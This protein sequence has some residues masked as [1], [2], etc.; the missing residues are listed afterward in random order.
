MIVRGGIKLGPGS[1]PASKAG[2]IWGR[3]DRGQIGW[4]PN[5]PHPYGGSWYIRQV[6]SPGTVKYYATT[7]SGTGAAKTALAVDGHRQ[8]VARLGTGTT[9]TG[10]AGS[11]YN[12]GTVVEFSSTSGLTTYETVFRIPTLPDG[13][14]T[15][16]MWCGFHDSGSATDAVDGIYI[17]LTTAD[18]EFQFVTSNNSTRTTTDTGVTA[19]GGT[20][21]R[22]RIEITNNSEARCYL[23]AFATGPLTTLVATNSTNIPSGSTR[24]TFGG[25]LN[26]IK[27]AG[28]TERTLDFSYQ[29][30]LR[31][32]IQ[33]GAPAV[34]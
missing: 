13:T 12:T 18:T 34:W 6:G 23:A 9:T 24:T 33:S 10:R 3:D 29:R 15:F 25:G 1:D 7:V 4:T 27:S 19:A 21:Y 32:T 8:C 14:E 26:I 5:R 22:L 2:A 16:S 11:I 28:T 30:S 31:Q 17:K 20:W